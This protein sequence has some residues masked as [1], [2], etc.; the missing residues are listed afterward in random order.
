MSLPVKRFPNKLAPTVPNNIPRNP[1]FC[2]FASTPFINKPD[3]S[4]HLTL[5]M[6]SFLSSFEIIYVVINDPNILLW[7]VAS[8]ADATAVNPYDI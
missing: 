5:L 6:T 8:V 7:I 3:S 2:S 4:R 1:P